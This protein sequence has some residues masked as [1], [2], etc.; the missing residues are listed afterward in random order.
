VALAR[1]IETNLQNIKHW[2]KR[3]SWYRPFHLAYTGWRASH[4][5]LPDWVLL[6]KHNRSR[7][8]YIQE[9]QST[10]R[11]RILVAT[12]TG[13]HLPSMTV[14]S[15][16]GVALSSRGAGVDFLLC[17]G[18]LP[19]CMMCEIN[20]YSDVVSFGV[21]G[22][23]DR[24]QSCYR[25]A[26]SMLKQSAI[27]HL[28]IGANLSENE[29]KQA[30]FLAMTIL[31]HEIRG[32]AIDG[33]S[34]GEHA[35]AGALRFFARGDLEAEPE[36][37]AVLRRYFEAALLTYYACHR[38]LANG[39]YKTVVLN[40]GIYIP[41]GV[42]AETARRLGMKVITWHQAYRR[43]CFIFNHGETYHH[44]LINEPIS[45]WESMRW[46]VRQQEQIEMYLK[47]RWFGINDWVKFQQEPNFDIKKIKKETG[48]DFIK[49]TVGLLTNVVWDAQLH[50]KAN[51]FPS[52]LEWLRKTITYFA[53]R[54]DL[55]LL[56][57]IHPAELTGTLPSRQPAIAEIARIFPQL[58]ENVFIIP[59]ESRI[60][61]YVAMSQCNA[62]LIYGTKTGVELT[63]LGIP[64]IVA[65]EAWIRG[66]GV[67]LDAGSEIDYFRILDTLPLPAK[68]DEPTR[69]RA[70][71]YAY[72]FFFRRM[73]PLE[74]IQERKG[75]PPFGVSINGI[76]DLAPGK[77][78]GLDIICNGI[79]SGSP[80][81]FPAEEEFYT[82]T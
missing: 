32:F 78:L 20:W 61:T 46:D 40:H 56:I 26:A 63:A 72:H 53:R 34:V 52:M 23:S 77:S 70:L 74:S 80:F 37:E 65:G 25:P 55:Q 82:I 66:K 47:S 31:H 48:I 79:L 14:E 7:W 29:R 30:R 57:R 6:L 13:G 38:L 12:G 69:V 3:W 35:M 68:L 4:G 28:G 21:N 62:V 18:A 10:S 76:H 45:A 44:G 51:A 59:P 73:I 50:Y 67:T 42:I 22:P 64:V 24:C 17:D 43:G 15:L 75:W 36:A 49:P 11:E 19:A 33:V 58:P 2:L 71:K 41:Q 5:G 27:S 9:K 60:S 54:P 8:K 1:Y 16:L 39:R 81:I